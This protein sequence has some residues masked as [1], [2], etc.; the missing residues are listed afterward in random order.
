MHMH[1]L[2]PGSPGSGKTFTMSGRED[3]IGTDDYQGGDRY[4]GITS[5]SVNYLYQQLREKKHQCKYQLS[6][7]YLEIYNEGGWAAGEEEGRGGV[8]CFVWELMWGWM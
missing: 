6:A 4:D 3:V 8:D 2:G 7:S 1:T 5:R